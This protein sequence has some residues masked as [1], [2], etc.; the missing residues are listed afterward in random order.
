[1]CIA[2]VHFSGGGGTV[3]QRAALYRLERMRFRQLIEEIERKYIGIFLW[4]KCKLLIFFCTCK[5]WQ[6]PLPPLYPSYQS[7]CCYYNAIP[8]STGK[9]LGRWGGTGH[10]VIVETG[11]A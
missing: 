7:Y 6:I 10:A 9:C 2:A 8:F 3:R 5:V 4:G 11:E 1:M